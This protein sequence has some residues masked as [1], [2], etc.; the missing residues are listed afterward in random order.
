MKVKVD[1]AADDAAN[2]DDAVY[3]IIANNS[4][5]S[6]HI[7]VKPAQVDPAYVN[8]RMPPK[9]FLS[10]TDKLLISIKIYNHPDFTADVFITN[11][12]YG[13]YAHEAKSCVLT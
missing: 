8:L 13:Y 10:Q 2:A 3:T 9:V 6:S 4:Y 5:S 11:A 1:A 12:E 7:Y